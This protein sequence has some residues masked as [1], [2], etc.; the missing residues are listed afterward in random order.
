LLDVAAHSMNNAA[1]TTMSFT[2]P[3]TQQYDFVLAC[4]F[5]E[6]ADGTTITA[7]AAVPLNYLPAYTQ[8]AARFGQCFLEFTSWNSAP[9]VT[10]SATNSASH[11][12]G[13]GVACFLPVAPAKQTWQIYTNRQSDTVVNSKTIA[14]PPTGQAYPYA[15]CEQVGSVRR[16]SRFSYD[17]TLSGNATNNVGSGQG[18]GIGQYGAGSAPALMWGE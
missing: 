6:V 1:N 14:S 12:Y 18:W 3:P 15:I 5:D 7:G 10:A 17:S 16:L 2:S 13:G 11:V 4:F 9:V 8:I